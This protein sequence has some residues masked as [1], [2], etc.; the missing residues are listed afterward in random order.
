MQ[1]E[2]FFDILCPWCYIGKRRLDAALEGFAHRDRV[3]IVWRSLELAPDEGREPGPTAAEEMAEWM[4]PG[5]VPARVALIQ[6]EGAEVGLT[7]DLMKARPVST[8]DAHRVIHLADREG[9]AGPMAEQLYRAYH[10][11]GSNIADPRALTELAVTAGLDPTKVGAVLRSDDYA[12]TVV[13]DRQRAAALGV[14]GVPS[15]SIDGRPAFSGVQSAAALRAV[16]DRARP[17]TGKAVQTYG[18]AAGG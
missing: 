4:D 15:L 18:A 6:R 3:R 12:N 5:A 10:T 11:E 7:L 16:L 9:R 2:I 17:S 1:L 8:Y 14:T 13:H